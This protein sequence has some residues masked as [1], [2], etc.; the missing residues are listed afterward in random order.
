MR[1]CSQRHDRRWRMP[2]PAS[3]PYSECRSASMSGHWASSPDQVSPASDAPF[4]DCRAV[5]SPPSYH[6]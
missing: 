1:T 5:G 4:R 2:L 3:M 6:S